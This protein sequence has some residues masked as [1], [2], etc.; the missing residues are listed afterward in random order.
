MDAA[1]GRINAEIKK[2]S[3]MMKGKGDGLWSVPKPKLLGRADH[4]I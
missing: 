3:A 4:K 2:P 1:T